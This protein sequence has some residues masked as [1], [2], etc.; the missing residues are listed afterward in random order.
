MMSLPGLFI[1]AG[2]RG[3]KPRWAGLVS[4]FGDISG[5][6]E[7]FRGLRGKKMMEMKTNEEKKVTSDDV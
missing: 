3:Q 1:E 2:G 5:V 4:Y 6:S 7:I